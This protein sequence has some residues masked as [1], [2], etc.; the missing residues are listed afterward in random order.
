MQ[1]TA[2]F[3]FYS[4]HVYSRPRFRPSPNFLAKNCSLRML[5]LFKGHRVRSAQNNSFGPILE[6]VRN[7]ADCTIRAVSD[8]L[9]L[10][11]ECIRTYAGGL[12][13]GRPERANVRE[14]RVRACTPPRNPS[15]WPP[16]CGKGA[17]NASTRF[18][19][20]LGWCRLQRRQR[21]SP[22]QRVA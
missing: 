2:F 6:I 13:E 16:P 22:R 1:S 14:A 10:E 5:S 17:C 7:F 3:F 21:S 8:S 11:V 19:S 20:Q 9:L 12:T 4:R 18:S 15:A